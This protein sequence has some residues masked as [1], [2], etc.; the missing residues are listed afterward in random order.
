[1][2]GGGSLG[3]AATGGNGQ[4]RWGY[5]RVWRMGRCC[6]ASASRTGWRGACGRRG[7]AATFIT[8]SRATSVRGIV[9][10]SVI[11]ILFDTVPRGRISYGETTWKVICAWRGWHRG[12][13]T[14]GATERSTHGHRR[15]RTVR[16]IETSLNEILSLWLGN[17]RL[18]LCGRERIDETGL[19]N[20]EK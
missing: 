5:A 2:G 12:H 16:R 1:M 4:W 17:E 20:D 6:A 10:V 11:I 9:I 14:R 3:G 8:S 13:W 15:Y 7:P 19:G 18:K